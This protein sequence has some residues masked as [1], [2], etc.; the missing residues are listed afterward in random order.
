MI[1]LIVLFK[2]ICLKEPMLSRNWDACQILNFNWRIIWLYVCLQHCRTPWDAN[3]SAGLQ[4]I[5]H[6]GNSWILAM[7]WS[8]ICRSN[9][10]RCKSTCIL[11]GLH[12][13]KRREY[14]S[15][16]YDKL[17]I[18]QKTLWWSWVSFLSYSPT[19]FD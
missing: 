10:I 2:N 8:H 12:C 13:K 14:S 5:F 11:M 18:N 4:T 15:N 9:D 16:C 1:N 17:S 7:S 3:N 19:Q 6:G